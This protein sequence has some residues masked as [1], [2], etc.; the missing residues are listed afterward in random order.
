MLIGRAKFECVETG[1]DKLRETVHEM[2]EFLID[3]LVPI[4]KAGKVPILVGGG[5]NNAYP[6]MKAFFL[7]HNKKVNVA[8]LDP[9][10]DYRALE[11]R[12]SGNSFSYAISI[13]DLMTKFLF[14]A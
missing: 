1:F 9:H 10:A 11:G 12:H 8:N 4:Y 3:I 13:T 14:S 5:H 2:D 6:L 7:A